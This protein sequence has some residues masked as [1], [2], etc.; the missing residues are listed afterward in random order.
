MSQVGSERDVERLGRRALRGAGRAED[1]EDAIAD[2]L[3]R[4]HRY[5]RPSSVSWVRLAA[6][7]CFR[8]AVRRSRP[9]EVPSGLEVGERL[10]GPDGGLE[11]VELSEVWGLLREQDRLVLSLYAEIGDDALCALELGVTRSAF[12]NRL[13]R[14]RKRARDLLGW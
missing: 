12:A 2:L 7:S 4:W 14:A 11:A 1:V 6:W 5:G 8:D 13:S 9:K 10:S 3:C